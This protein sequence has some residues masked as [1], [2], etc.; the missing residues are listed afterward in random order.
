MFW[1]HDCSAELLSFTQSTVRSRRPLQDQSLSSDTDTSAVQVYMAIPKPLPSSASYPWNSAVIEK[2][3][4]ICGGTA[5]A[6]FFS[7]V[8]KVK[9]GVPFPINAKSFFFHTSFIFYN[10]VT[11]KMH[12]HNFF[13]IGDENLGSVRTVHLRPSAFV[14]CPCA[15]V[16]APNKCELPNGN[17]S[18]F[19][20]EPDISVL[21]LFPLP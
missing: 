20:R 3:Q 4:L 6:I 11:A 10:A 12:K 16:P 15:S 17:F 13:T 8:P 1:K 21:L 19:A 18:P 14:C 7:L 2:N 9:P 5:D